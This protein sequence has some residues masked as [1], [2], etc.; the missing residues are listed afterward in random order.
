[1]TRILARLAIFDLLVL[2]AAVGLG[3]YSRARGGLRDFEDISYPLH[4]YIALFAVIYNL[5]LHCLVFIYFL[6]T[7]RWVKE[8]ALAYNLP[9]EPWPK[10]TRELKRR[11]FPPALFAMLLPIGTAA[12][13]MTQ[14]HE[15]NAWAPH[16]HA[17]L[18]LLS[19]LVNVW[20]LRIEYRNVSSNGDLIDQVVV[21]VERI[22]AE[23]GLPPSDQA[24][25]QP[26]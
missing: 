11:T 10:L 24:W 17:G 1:M 23:K 19:L 4:Q 5:G 13:G 20:A 14:V 7:G 2:A 6:G 15:Q 16:M 9:D 18:A 12:A 8:V 26:S 22:R 25:D 21:E 3:Y